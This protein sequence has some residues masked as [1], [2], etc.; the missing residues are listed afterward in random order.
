MPGFEDLVA[1]VQ[2]SLEHD[3]R[4]LEVAF[5]RQSRRSS[6]YQFKADEVGVAPSGARDTFELANE[7]R[8]VEIRPF[9]AG[10]FTVVLEGRLCVASVFGLGDPELYAV[11]RALV[12]AGRLFGVRDA[13]A[14]RHQV[15]L[16][17]SE[18]L[19][20]AQAVVVYR[21]ALNEPRGGL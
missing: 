10:Q 3:D 19:L 16:S 7:Y 6:H 21:L 15:Q 17:R 9:E 5:E 2:V 20:G 1:N 13:H 18:Q 8:C 14:R 4:V 12:L 11:Q